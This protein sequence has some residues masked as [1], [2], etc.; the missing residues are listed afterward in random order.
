MARHNIIFG[1]DQAVQQG[2]RY[3]DASQGA[4][5][6]GGP[7]YGGPQQTQW[8]SD[9]TPQQTGRTAN[10]YDNLEAMYARPSAT[11]HDT[12]RMTMRDAL[13]AI[14]VTLGIIVVTGFA[15]GLL[16]LVL[17]LVGGP[18]GMQIGLVIAMGAS[19]IGV[20]GGLITGLINGFKKKPSAIAVIAYAVFEGLLLGGISS[21]FEYTA[22]PGIA[23]QA[24]VATFMVAGVIL[25]LT[26][27]GILRTSPL[28]TKVFSFAILAY[29]GFVLFNIVYLLITGNDL[30]SG[31]FGLIIGGLAVVMASYSLTSDIEQVRDAAQGGVPRAYAWRCA[32]GVAATL[33]WMYIEILRIIAIFRDN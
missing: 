28:L 27:L 30:R 33:V 17:S 21:V 2:A 12:G 19:I 20:I 10:G 16:P 9:F 18:T 25:L 1:R 7:Q 26:N 31:V 13:N 6:Q 3:G 4:P 29:L 32:F 22:Y 15:V 23:L 11:G 14:S 24:V 5:Q 8:A